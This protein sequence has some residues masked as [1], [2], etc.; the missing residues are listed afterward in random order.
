MLLPQPCHAASEKRFLP[1]SLS[2][3]FQFPPPCSLPAAPSRNQRGSQLC[4]GGFDQRAWRLVCLPGR[5]SC[6]PQRQQAGCFS[7]LAPLLT[8]AALSVSLESCPS[9]FSAWLTV[10][11][12]R[13]SSWPVLALH[14]P[15]P[16]PASDVKER[17]ATLPSVECSETVEIIGLI[18]VCFCPRAEGGRGGGDWLGAGASRWSC[19]RRSR[20][21]WTWFAGPRRVTGVRSQSLITGTMIRKKFEMV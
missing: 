9:A 14:P 8:G 21:T 2:L 20:I 17:R 15:S 10:W 16:F 5:Q 1:E 11:L 18:S 3:L 19:E 13:P 4:S 7:P 6:L 12:R